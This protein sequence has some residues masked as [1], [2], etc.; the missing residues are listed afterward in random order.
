MFFIAILDIDEGKT[1]SLEDV[2][3]RKGDGSVYDPRSNCLMY[4]LLATYLD[5]S[6][7]LIDPDSCSNA[8]D[9]MQQ[10][11]FTSRLRCL[12]RLLVDLNPGSNVSNKPTPSRSVSPKD[13]NQRVQTKSNKR[14]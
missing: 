6:K 14:E 9:R 12:T 10:A 7:Q 1:L 3:D 5:E 11:L 2:I 8:S 4:K 13:W